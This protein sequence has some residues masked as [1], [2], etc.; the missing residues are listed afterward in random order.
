MRERGR[1]RLALVGLG[2]RR[3][4]GRATGVS[5]RRVALSVL[6]VAV[7]IG[8]VVTVS[9]IALGLASQSTVQ[10]DAV[11]YWI[12]PEDGG[13]TTAVAVDGPKLGAVHETAASLSTDDRIDHATPVQMSLLPVQTPATEGEEYVLAV[14][15][16]P[17]ENAARIAGLS[18]RPLQPADPHYADG[19]Y[20]GPWTGEAVVS[21]A[22]AELLG[23]AEGDSIHPQTDEQS[24]SFTVTHVDGAGL[25]TGGG[26]VPVMLVHLS[27][28][29]SLTGA[30]ASDQ[31]NQIL[32]R[33]DAPG[34][35]SRLAR[36]YPR[37]TVVSKG[38]LSARRLGTSNLAL[39]VGVAAFLVV[40]VIGVLFVATMMGL[41]ITADRRQLAVLDAIG[42][43]PWSRA[44]VI[45]AETLSITVCGGCCGVLLGSG[46]I[47]VTNLLAEQYLP[48]PAVARFHPALIAYGIGIA[49]L[50][51]LFAAPYP[52][53]LSHRTLGK[54]DLL[55]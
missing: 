25:S 50:I 21:D 34:V 52:V 51:G 53:F 13:T 3:V 17:D 31:A 39:A 18:T 20:D 22:A 4:V 49:I 7:A 35:E 9:G 16:V 19:Q 42:F 26:S 41:E 5:P 40:F 43:S 1:R 10:S 46:G 54:E 8:F 14:G 23:V 45:L 36:T 38:D 44:Q 29:Q 15:V 37:T 32:V 55:Q 47:A 27:E 12:V 28:L 24:R 11:D 33:T 2:V 30:E 48:V 6:A